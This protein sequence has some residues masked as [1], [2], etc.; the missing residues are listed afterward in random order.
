MG[1]ARGFVGKQWDTC[2]VACG[3]R[4]VR[5]A[6]ACSVSITTVAARAVATTNDPVGKWAL[7]STGYTG[8]GPVAE[9]LTCHFIAKSTV[10]TDLSIA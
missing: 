1:T 10:T 5:V 2:D 8:I 3:P 9:T 7:D 4:I 6:G